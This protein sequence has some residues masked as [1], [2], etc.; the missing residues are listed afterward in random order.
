MAAGFG[1]MA[2]KSPF[3]GVA[4]GEGGLRGAQT[5]TQLGQEQRA[6][7]MHQQ[8]INQAAENLA[9]RAE[10][11]R[12]SIGNNPWVQNSDGSLTPRPGGPAD[13]EYAAKI[14]QAK[15]E[16]WKPIFD[17]NT[18]QYIFFN[19]KNLDARDAAGNRVTAPGTAPGAPT[20]QP[21][22]IQAS[23]VQVAS[24]GPV[25]GILG[26]HA[27]VLA[28]G[29]YDYSHD[30][31]YIEKG[32]EVPEPKPVAGKS[33]DSIKTQ[34]EY[35][36]QTGKLPPLARGNN[37]VA[38]QTNAYRNSVENY[39]N[40]LARSRDISPQQTAEMWRQAPGMLRF[41]LGPDGRSTVA[42]GTATRHL[43]TMSD[44][45]RTWNAKADTGDWQTLNRVKAAIAREF[46]NDSV[47]NLDAAR[48]IVGPEIIKAIGVAGAG[49][50]VERRAAAAFAA[51]W[52]SPDQAFGAIRTVQTLM[53][54]QLEGRERQASNAGVSQERFKSLIGDRPYELLK[55]AQGAGGQGAAPVAIPPPEKREINKV[56]ENAHGKKAKW[57]DHGWEPIP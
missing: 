27:K 23:N 43:D 3:A 12:M 37:P 47:T 46:G 49:T 52:S 33:V 40:A 20:Q 2:S 39:A 11:V 30:A 44:L 45:V 10:Q 50:E 51:P 32:M 18:G 42:L 9:L 28:S 8:Q 16:N 4:I 17:P 31:P 48:Q 26:D 36:L 13:P 15:G 7:A 34:A 56:Y 41:I 5:Y 38:F 54:G 24:A 1:M 6:E 57:T 22:P 21:A 29:A 19:T 55:H 53:G 35:F 25:N 14:A